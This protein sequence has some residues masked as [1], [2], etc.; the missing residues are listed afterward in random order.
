MNREQAIDRMVI[1]LEKLYELAVA[2]EKIAP[3]SASW[4][5]LPNFKNCLHPPPCDPGLP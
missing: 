3:P 2:K 4:N 1:K 5:S